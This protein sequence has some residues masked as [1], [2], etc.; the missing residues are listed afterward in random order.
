MKLKDNSGGFWGDLIVR[1]KNVDM[2][3]KQH[4]IPDE[5]FTK[6]MALEAISA[7]KGSTKHKLNVIRNESGIHYNLV[8]DGSYSTGI[9]KNMSPD[10]TP[11]ELLHRL[12][13]KDRKWHGINRGANY[14]LRKTSEHIFNGLKIKRFTVAPKGGKRVEIGW[15]GENEKIALIQ[16]QGDPNN[17]YTFPN[18]FVTD[19]PIVA[20]KF[21]G[22]S[23]ELV[24]TIRTFCINFLK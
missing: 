11:Y 21:R 9:M 7:I 12:T 5:N 13:V 15:T 14:I 22:Y 4:L 18:G 23:E 17:K 19:A 16:D 2:I 3:V 24:Q 1:N 20:R 10:G 8:S 6:I